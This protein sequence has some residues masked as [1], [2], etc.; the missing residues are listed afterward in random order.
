MGKIRTVKARA[1]QEWNQVSWS[2]GPPRILVA[3]TWFPRRESLQ[4][5][6]RKENKEIIWN[7]GR[8]VVGLEDWE[9]GKK[10]GWRKVENGGKRK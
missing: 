8:E 10:A 3:S 4:N 6:E 9:C 5:S 1:V 7:T 2:P